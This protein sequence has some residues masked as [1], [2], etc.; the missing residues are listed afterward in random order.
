M[1][2]RVFSAGE[3]GL[4]EETINSWLLANKIESD[5]VVQILQSESVLPKSHPGSSQGAQRRVTVSI[6]YE[7]IQAE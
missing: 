5:Q 7:G 6:W 1:K 2:V 4:L 3:D